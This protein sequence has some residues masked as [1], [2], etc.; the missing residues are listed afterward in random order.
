MGLRMGI[1]F[2]APGSLQVC[3]KSSEGFWLLRQMQQRWILIGRQLGLQE[4]ILEY[5]SLQLIM[6]KTAICDCFAE[7]QNR[8]SCWEHW[9]SCWWLG[10]WWGGR[11]IGASWRG[12]WNTSW[13]VKTKLRPKTINKTLKYSLPRMFPWKVRKYCNWSTEQGDIASAQH[14]PHLVLEACLWEGRFSIVRYLHTGSLL[15]YRRSIKSSN[16]LLDMVFWI[17]PLFF[18]VCPISFLVCLFKFASYPK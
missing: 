4:F 6:L 5:N 14:Y 17:L 12:E 8:G 18:F 11:E 13:R 7:C 16:I 15:H 1:V 10:R 3:E 9:N 2:S